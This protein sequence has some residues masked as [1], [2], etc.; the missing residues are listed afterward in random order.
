MLGLLWGNPLRADDVLIQ[1]TDSLLIEINQLEGLEK[2]SK[3]LDLAE[4]IFD[5]KPGQATGLILEVMKSRAYADDLVIQIRS[6]L[7]LGKL[8]QVEENRPL[9]LTHLDTALQLSNLAKEH[10]YKSEILLR[11]GINHHR[12]GSDLEALTVLTEALK[13]SRVAGNYYMQGSVLSILGTIYR[14]NGLYDRAIEY[15][16]KGSIAYE[17]ADNQEG[18]TWASY[19]SGRIYKDLGMSDKALGY[20]LA[21]LS[22][23]ENLAAIDGN[24][25]GV[26]ICLEQ[27]GL[28]NLEGG[29]YET[30]ITHI[31]KLLTLHQQNQSVYGVSNAY[32]HLGIIYYSLGQ[33]DEAE[34]YLAEALKTKLELGDLFSLGTIYEHQGLIRI[35]RGDLPGGL[36]LL[37]LG[38]KKAEENDQMRVQLNIYARLTETYKKMNNL[39]QAMQMQEKQIEIQQSMLAGTVP[40][41]LEQ[42]QAVY[43]MDEKNDQIADLENDNRMAQ[44]QLRQQR[45]WQGALII[46][47]ALSLI[48]LVIIFWSN[49]QIRK[50]NKVLHAALETN[51]KLFTIISHDLRGPIG[52]SLS[53]SE[54]LLED[55]TG[56]VHSVP[57]KQVNALYRSLSQAYDL[58]INLLDWSKSQLNRIE[59]NPKSLVLKKEIDDTLELLSH[60]IAAK[61]LRIQLEMESGCQVFADQEML[62][63][64]LR[65]LI[66][67]AIKYCHTGGSVEISCTQQDGLTEIRVSDNGVGMSPEVLHNLFKTESPVSQPGT[68]GEKGSGL[69]LMLVQEFVHK[70]GGTLKVDSEPGHGS[71]FSFTLPTP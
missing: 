8:Y 22:I 58:L 15:S 69:G 62:K 29:D 64:I 36:E 23:Y 39:R 71:V 13:A 4:K 5:L 11:T 52:S 67:N 66:A 50:K 56:E 38:L 54:V 59:F 10:W 1:F 42:F 3:Q 6:H 68:S 12:E 34:R 45:T 41:N 26:A 44:L 48:I 31:E 24:Q 43:E 40:D 61:D 47:V 53:L 16:A 51:N 25:N 35:A 55:L 46:G 28:L 17:K 63:T 9:S 70:H 33:Y 57:Q 2:A 19:L 20:F 37:K 60:F 32:Q 65:N 14:Q 30:A 7:I 18:K 27:I 21:A 49:W